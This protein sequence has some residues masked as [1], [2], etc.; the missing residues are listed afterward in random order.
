MT[1]MTAEEVVA[2]DD[3]VWAMNEDENACAIF[4]E[5]FNPD[6]GTYM[7]ERDAQRFRDCVAKLVALGYSESDARE[8]MNVNLS[9]CDD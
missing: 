3:R 7:T 8:Y 5:V 2:Q 1:E 9:Y 4:N 6:D